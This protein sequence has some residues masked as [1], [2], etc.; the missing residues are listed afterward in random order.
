[1][2]LILKP[3]TWIEMCFSEKIVPIFPDVSD[4]YAHS[5]TRRI[6]K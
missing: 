2:P 6:K 5:D 4:L 3:K 1:M